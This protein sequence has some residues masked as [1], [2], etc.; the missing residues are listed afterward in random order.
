MSPPGWPPRPFQ[1]PGCELLRAR[2]KETYRCPQLDR[3][4]LVIPRSDDSIKSRMSWTS[5][6][7]GSFRIASN[8]WLVFS[9]DRNRRRK[10]ELMSRI[11]SGVK[12]F[13]SSPMVLTPNACVL[14]ALTVFENGRTSLVMTE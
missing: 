6:D 1:Y 13:R 11:C 8:A 4:Y 12:P 9:F 10:A 14:R 5:G 2:G 3:I 7:T